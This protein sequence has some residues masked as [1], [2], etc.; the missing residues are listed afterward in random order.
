M[1]QILSGATPAKKKG[2]GKKTRSFLRGVRKLLFGLATSTVSSSLTR[3]IVF[4]NLT[5]LAVLVIGI[6]YLNQF[7]EGLID[8]RVRSLLTQGK[9][10]AGAVSA[11]AALDVDG[12]TLPTERLF[13]L[14]AGESFTPAEDTFG[15]F[16]FPIDPERTA[17][18]LRA[19][20]SPTDTRARVYDVAGNL[21][22]DSN[23]LQST[24]ILRSNLPPPEGEEKIGISEIW[25]R[26]MNWLRRADLPLYKE[27]GVTDGRSYPE[28]AMALDGSDAS[29]VRVNEKGRLIVSVAVPIQRSRV[30]A[31]ALLL[32]TRD[33]DIDKIVQAE[34]WGIVRVFLIAALV[35]GTMSILL[36]GTIAG[37]VRR[38]SEAAE[39]VRRG[40]KFREEIPDFSD[41]KDEIG[42]LSQSLRD[43]TNTLFQR[44]D[45]IE[46][47]AADVSHELKNPLTS[48][49]SA[50]ETLPL[51]KNDSAR[52]R[53]TNIIQHDVRRLDRLISDIS[54]ASRLDAE[55]ARQES[56]AIDLHALLDT[57]VAI[58]NEIGGKRDTQVT[59]KTDKPHSKKA[60]AFKVN[61][62]DSRLGQVFVNLIDN[63]RSFTPEGGEVR[64]CLSH[65]A[66]WIKVT[67]DDDGPGIQ[68]EDVN[69]VFE[70]FY[71]DR[72]TGEDFGQNSGLGLSISKQIVEAYNGEISVSNRTEFDEETGE[73]V[74]KGAQFTVLL[75][76]ISPA[77]ASKS[78]AKTD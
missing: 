75:P 56:Q 33:G 28:V 44:M 51:A 8:A 52:E 27:L 69:R 49:R 57:I 1:R 30:I 17:P 67:V 43:M 65:A 35:T 21:V 74:V 25:K 50:V 40:V 58:Q 23:Q 22:V 45:A 55:L 10:I 68:A 31:G 38:L 7:R 4:L 71:T 34:R 77:L 39:R 13:E 48:L 78:D 53:L 26:F 73:E 42:H 59:L 19:A 32:S 70:R 9:I 41:R 14:Q 54:D 2:K 24:G 60:A 37:P 12:I 11:S 62:N 5:A 36:A 66:H 18:I 64:V 16:D 29:I 20:I 46:A 63:A 3:R 61:G 47:F 6:L 15:Y 76:S 72:P